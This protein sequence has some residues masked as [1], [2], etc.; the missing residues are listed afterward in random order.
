MTKRRTI[1][2]VPPCWGMARWWY[3]KRPGERA[4]TSGAVHDD[5]Q[6]LTEPSL[7]EP[8]PGRTR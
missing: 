1:T 7:V 8:E 3:A 5:A 4:A 2:S 6:V